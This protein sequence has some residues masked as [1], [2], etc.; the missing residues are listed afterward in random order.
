[1]A[2][3]QTF[4]QQ[5][6]T[7]NENV[8]QIQQVQSQSQQ[9][10]INNSENSQNNQQQSSYGPIHNTPITNNTQFNPME[11][12]NAPNVSQTTNNKPKI[13]QYQCW[14]PLEQME[15]YNWHP[16]GWPIDYEFPYQIDNYIN[17]FAGLTG[18]PGLAN[19]GLNPLLS[20]NP[21]ASLA[22]ATAL[23][24]DPTNATSNAAASIT[25][26]TAAMIPP[27]V[28]KQFSLFVFH[29]PEDIDDAGLLQLFA[30]YGAIRSNVMRQEN[31]RSR[32]FGF[33]HFNT[34]HEAQ[35][36]IDMMNG[37]Q[38]GRKRLRVSFKKDDNT[39]D[40]IASMNMGNMGNIGNLGNVPNLK[41][42]LGRLEEL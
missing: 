26:A 2:D 42:N 22:A 9:I 12:V 10:P 23:N 14:P 4:V 34:Q 3:S 17:G 32:G 1:M 29:L 40:V 6:Q 31:G 35:I 38:I 25:L 27:I 24:L 20:V 13:N 30:P 37:H 18:L 5:L 39:N 16:L 19:L 7:N 41:T 8:N 21:A 15:H 36:A 33:I 11:A 28:G